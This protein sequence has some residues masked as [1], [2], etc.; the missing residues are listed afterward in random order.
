MVKLTVN[1]VDYNSKRIDNRGAIISDF[2]DE[3]NKVEVSIKVEKDLYEQTMQIKNRNVS[4]MN[5]IRPDIL[6]TAMECLKRGE[7]HLVSKRYMDYI[8]ENK[9]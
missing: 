8:I 4:K 1:K 2:R 6:N 9:F 3:C 7:G 5:D